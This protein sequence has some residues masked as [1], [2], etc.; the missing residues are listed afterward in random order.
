MLGLGL[1]SGYTQLGLFNKFTF[2]IMITRNLLSRASCV[3]LVPCRNMAKTK[4]TGGGKGQGKVKGKGTSWQ[5][6]AKNLDK[7]F[8]LKAYNSQ[9][10]EKV[11]Q[12]KETY[13]TSITTQF[14]PNHLGNIKVKVDGTMATISE[15]ATIRFEAGKPLI[16]DCSLFPDYT[17]TIKEGIVKGAGLDVMVVND[18]DLKVTLPKL[19]GDHRKLLVERAKDESRKTVERIKYIRDACDRK[20]SKADDSV[21]PPDTARQIKGF[22]HEIYLEKSQE[23]KDL[24]KQKCADLEGKK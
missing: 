2:R 5:T 6:H 7:H 4:N 24:A 10:M 18:T 3:S 22:I 12:M 11:D 15:V 9:L 20:I 14:S 21:I 16:V 1:R 19:T 13:A 17:N 8:N 23:T